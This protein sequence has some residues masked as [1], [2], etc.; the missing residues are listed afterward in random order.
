MKTP[1]PSVLDASAISLS[2]LCLGH[3]LA[4]SLVAA[5][6]PALAAWAQ[7]EWAHAVLVGIAAPLSALALRRR[8]RN[9]GVALPAA[10]GLLL[11]ALGALGWPDH[12]LE[13]PL[14]VAGSLALAGAH[15]VN[16]RARH[17]DREGLSAF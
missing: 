1:P 9:A 8:G 3:C 13:V 14:T 10:A 16:W 11:L 2:G 5:L 17:A 4:L 7:V 15:L 6:S 12:R